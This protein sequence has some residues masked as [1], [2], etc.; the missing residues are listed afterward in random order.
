MLKWLHFLHRKK[1]IKLQFL[2]QLKKK[3]LLILVSEDP[4]FEC[5]VTKVLIAMINRSS[6]NR[7][8]NIRV[9]IDKTGT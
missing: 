7:I 4:Y 3:K 5:F 9:P 2:L 6:H 8:N 1:I